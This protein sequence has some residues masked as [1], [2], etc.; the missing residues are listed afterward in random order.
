MKFTAEGPLAV[1]L[2]IDGHPYLTLG[3][4]LVDV[5]DPRTGE[6][7]RRVPLAGAE[8]AALA[9]AAAR[10]AGEAWVGQDVAQRQRLLFALA[11]ALEQLSGHFAALL[12]AETGCDSQS[13]AAEV[14]AAAGA[15]RRA[16]PQA[17]AGVCVVVLGATRPLAT[18]VETLSGPLA[19]G[20]TAVIK[21]ST[22]APA[23]AFA[24][25]ELAARHGWPDGVINLVQGDEAAVAGLCALDEVAVIQC[26][27]DP[28]LRTRVATIAARYGKTLGGFA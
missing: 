12:V 13:A 20:C 3:E 9:Y 24:L 1:P 22:R 6:V 18:L 4:G 10:R 25:C 11:A 16:V 28:E 21:P 27:G 7:L 14:S 5:L 26:A 19:A 17:A 2:W 23:A 8:E 15:L